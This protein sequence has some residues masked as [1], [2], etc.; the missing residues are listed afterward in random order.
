VNRLAVRIVLPFALALL[1]ACGFAAWS[2]GRSV[3]EG[4]LADLRERTGLLAQGL[5]RSAELPM[6]AGDAAALG[7]LLEEAGRDPDVLDAVVVDAAG[8]RVAG[9]GKPEAPRQGRTATVLVLEEPV[10]TSSP[11]DP[12]GSA[13][14]LDRGA[15]APERALGELR[16]LVSLARTEARVAALEKQI[17]LAGLALLALC[18]AI[19]WA[20]VRLVGRP[21]R[22]LV[23][24]TDRIAAGDLP[25]RVAPSSTDEVGTLGRAFNRMA[26][27]LAAERGE[28]ERRVEA[29]TAELRRAQETLVRS[30]KLSAVGQLVAGVAHELNNPLTVVLGYAGLLAE[31]TQEEDTRR[32][33]QTVLQEAQ[34]S[35]KIVHNL[36]AFARK[37]PPARSEADLNDA[38]ARTVALRAYQLRSE[39]IRLDTDLQPDLP[40]TW[41]DFQ[42]LQQVILNLVVNAEQAIQECGRGSRIVVRTRAAGG[43]LRIEVEDDGPG[44]PDGARTRLFEPFF[45]TKDV[46]KGTGL[47]LSICWGIVSEHGGTIEVDSEVNRFSRFTVVLPIQAKPVAQTA[48]VKPTAALPKDPAPPRRRVL[49]VDDDRAVLQFVGDVLERSRAEVH[50]VQGGRE[51]IARLARGEDFDVVLCD[52]R[53]PDLDGSAVFRYLCAHRPEL[54]ERV[55]FATGDLANEASASF[56]EGTGRPVLAKPFEVDALRALVERV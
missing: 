25:V 35:Q 10:R 6:L 44:I 38:V 2:L 21:L 49:V 56:L 20:T 24:A 8:R 33:L 29:R 36:L 42:Q 52:L 1:A 26:E 46:G 7:E 9:L 39:K 14:A 50:P 5:A 23:E 4:A 55:V 45:T 30:E 32:K 54:E 15:A 53:M 37:Q 27:D 11:L 13:F 17:A 22:Q 40:R 41:A 16:L 34:R 47:G 28:L 31:K 19:G 51:A 48:E 43:A 3:R 18:A 12:E